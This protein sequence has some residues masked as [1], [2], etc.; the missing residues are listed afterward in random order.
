M[1]SYLLLQISG[2]ER[3]IKFFISLISHFETS[4]VPVFLYD[5]CNG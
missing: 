1:Y 3:N 2:K 4:L 5:W